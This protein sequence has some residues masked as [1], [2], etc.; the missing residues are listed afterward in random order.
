MSKTIAIINVGGTF[1][2]QYDKTKGDLVVPKNSFVI[3]NILQN[4]YITNQKPCL[5]G[6]IFKDSLDMDSK[7]RKNLIKRVQS[8]KEKKV[9]IIHGTDSMDKSAKSIANE[10]VDKQIVFVGAMQ[11]W[12]IEPV[13]ATGTLMMAIGFL[14]GSK[15]NGIYICMNGLI[16]HYKNIKKNHKKGMFECLQ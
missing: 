13:E 12:S 2:K 15:K 6:M 7:D 3:E 14:Q 8:L 9:I 4:I 11:P 16:E 10:I 5:Y 1:N